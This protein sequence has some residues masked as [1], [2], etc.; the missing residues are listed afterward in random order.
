M[1]LQAHK[2]HYIIS[3]LFIPVI[4]LISG[5]DN[6]TPA[7]DKEKLIRPAKIFTV[8]DP[9]EQAIRN[10]PGEVEANATSK[11][12][13]R[14]SG[15]V[16]DFPVKPGNTVEKGDVVAR[17]DPTDF[18]LQLDDRQ[19]RYDLAKSQFE[20]AKLL[21][22]RKLGS[23]SGFDEAKANLGVALSSLNV[24]KNNL[25]Y[26]YLHA[27]FSGNISKVFIKN[28]D[29]VQAKQTIIDLQ[30]LDIIDISIQMPENIASRV[31]KGSK[32]QPTVIFDSHPDQ[33]FLA[34]VKEWDTQADPSTLTYKVVFSLPTPKDFN[35][36]PGMSANI[37]IDL[38][39]ITHLESQALILPISAVF[40]PEDKPLN[41][42]KKFVWKVDPNTMKVHSVPV[43]VGEVKS[44]GIEVLSGLSAGDQIIAAGSNFLT[45]GMQIRPW[46]RE[47][48]L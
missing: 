4:L 8:V 17:L 26:T 12:A 18:E 21:L 48:G 36:L 23:Q 35:A 33:E 28:F 44:T 7:P 9:S 24:A 31:K 40:S 45:E 2:I 11:L 42:P 47:K 30:T 1:F 3:T 43:E 10:F 13:F 15:Q 6:S 27:P 46:N 29:H 39:K 38:S 22:A 25:E 34:T 32:H 37:R 19:A 5:C 16:I 14:V 20:Q 41:H